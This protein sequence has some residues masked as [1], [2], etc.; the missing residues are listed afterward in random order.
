MSNDLYRNKEFTVLYVASNFGDTDKVKTLLE[1]G[2]D[3]NVR[4]SG[5]NQTPLHTCGNSKIA[6]MLIS[7]GADLTARNKGGKTPY[8]DISFHYCISEKYKE[9]DNI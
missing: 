6:E 1:N 5:Y 3:P 7:Y 8:E 2:H 9:N 4:A